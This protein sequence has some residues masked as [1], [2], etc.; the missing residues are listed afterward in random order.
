MARGRPILASLIVSIG[1]ISLAVPGSSAFAGEF[2]ILAGAFQQGWGWAVAGLVAIVLAAMY[3]LRLV[4]AVLHREPG[5]AVPEQAPDLRPAELCIVGAL[6]VAD[7]RALGLAGRDQQ[8]LL[9]LPRRSDTLLGDASPRRPQVGAR[10]HLGSLERPRHLPAGRERRR[11]QQR[12]RS[13]GSRW[14]PRSRS[15]PRRRSRC[16]S[17]CS[18]PRARASRPA[19]LVCLAG[20]AAALADC[21]SALRPQRPCAGGDRQRPLPRSLRRAGGDDRGRGGAADRARLLRRAGG[22]RPCRPSAS[23]CSPRPAA[24]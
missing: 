10:L 20:Y 8:A 16:S 11:D 18:C 5:E 3:M 9:R 12:R 14:R 24:A 23:R 7:A 4:S 1:V 6:L 22:A 19:W 15:P 2:M 21:G 13:T 17:P